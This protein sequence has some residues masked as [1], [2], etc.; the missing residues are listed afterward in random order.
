MSV[1]AFYP[2]YPAPLFFSLMKSLRIGT[3]GSALAL[4][5][6]ERVR[7]LLTQRGIWA[8]PVVIRTSGDE[9]SPVPAARSDESIKGL[10]TKEL[11]EAL[12]DGRIDLAIHSLKDVSAVLPGGLTLAAFPE[13]EDPRDALVSRYGQGLDALPRGATVGTA[14][15]RRSAAL[16]SLR[17]D[18]RIVPLRGNVPTRLARVDRGDL[19]AAILALAGL[20]RLGLQRSAVPLDPADFVPAPGQGTLA[21]E[22]RSDDGDTVATVA[23]LDDPAIRIAAEAERAAMEELEGGCRVPIGAICLTE[24]ARRILLVKVFSPDG[25]R[26]LT[27]RTEIDPANPRAGGRAAARELIAAGAAGLIQEARNLPPTRSR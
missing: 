11:E 8:E 22:T 5:Q 18:L 12:L 4:W 10:F 6:A 15:L 9:G 7:S 1:S 19:D 14:S 20:K 16:L 24:G 13:R 3:R 25:S 21:I 27:S 2:R 26:M 23:L 17:P